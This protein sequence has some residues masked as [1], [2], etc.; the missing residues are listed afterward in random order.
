MIA[1]GLDDGLARDALPQL[2]AVAEGV[3]KLQKKGDEHHAGIGDGVD[4]LPLTDA[5]YTLCTPPFGV[6]TA[7]VFRAWDDLGGPAALRRDDRP[8]RSGG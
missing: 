1:S 2:G 3:Q 6:S 4:P 5:T 7:A 8:L